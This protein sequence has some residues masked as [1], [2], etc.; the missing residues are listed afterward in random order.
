MQKILSWIFP[1][2]CGLCVFVYIPH[3]SALIFAVGC[4]LS[5]PIPKIR[6]FLASKGLSGKFKGVLLAAIF[7]SGIMATPAATPEQEAGEP[8]RDVISAD[9]SDSMGQDEP[10]QPEKVELE[11]VEPEPEEAPA[12]SRELP[13]ESKP[14]AKP[15]QAPAP[16]AEPVPEPEPALT[17]PPEKPPV[18][19]ST[20]GKIRRG[21]W[22][23]GSYLGSIESDKYHDHEC[24]A[25]KKI[26]PEN[27]IWFASEDEAKASGYSRCGICW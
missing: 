6:E 8:T 12:A 18:N 26:L 25:A 24:R 17:P 7:F 2:F 19:R 4:V 27:E 10:A 13:E 16:E 3:F 5:L 9:E 23:D 1:V 21:N 14:A 20:S 11:V 22:V 15:I